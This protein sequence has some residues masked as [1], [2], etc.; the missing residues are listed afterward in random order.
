MCEWLSVA[1]NL[2]FLHNA[3][4]G[5]RIL[6]HK[7]TCC[8]LLPRPLS[9]TQSSPSMSAN[10][11]QVAANGSVILTHYYETFILS[12]RSIKYNW[13]FLVA[14]ITLPVLGCGLTRTFK[15]YGLCRS[16]SV[17]QFI[18]PLLNT[19]QTWPLQP[20]SP[21]QRIHRYLHPFLT[22]Y[23][24]VIRPELHET[25]TVPTKH[26]IYHHIRTTGPPEFTRI[27]HMA[28]DCLAAAKQMFAKLEEMGFCQK[29]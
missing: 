26:G 28:Q 19:Y 10:I 21:H 29:V 11:R 4:A 12:F 13:K 20:H 9:R 23:L 25:P 3:G 17:C 8:S 15:T 16:L 5:V 22:S 27:R 14:D 6:V 1:T 18:F 2:F 24:E 7:G